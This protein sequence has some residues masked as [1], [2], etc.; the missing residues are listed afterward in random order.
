MALA[1]LV[2]AS[3]TTVLAADDDS[4]LK[5]LAVQNRIR[6]PTHEFTAWA[7]ALPLDAF[8][9][10][11]T[12]S[13]AYTIHFDDLV[14][15]EV[16]QYTYSKAVKTDLKRDLRSL[17]TPLGPTPFERVRSYAVTNLVL[18]PVYCK[19]AVLNK[20]VLHGEVFA[21]VG[22]GFGKMSITQRPVVDAGIGFRLY[23]GRALSFRFDARNYAFVNAEDIHNEIWLALGASLSF[24]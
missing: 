4:G 18:K 14:A 6:T 9:K 21:L 15:W 23:T 7:G 1:L 22:G 16:V 5:Y 12:L 19:L 8:T 3:P 11:A 13:G 10:G 2:G 24:D 20:S 17:A